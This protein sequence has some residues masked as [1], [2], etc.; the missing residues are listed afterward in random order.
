MVAD[1]SQR[2]QALEWNMENAER[3]LN[4]SIGFLEGSRRTTEAWVD[5]VKLC[6]DEFDRHFAV[7][8]E[9]KRS[10]ASPAIKP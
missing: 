9:F 8:I 3:N 4:L 1:E 7:L 10:H 6:R 5:K 2:R